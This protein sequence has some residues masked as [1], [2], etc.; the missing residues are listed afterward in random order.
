MVGGC[1]VQP[2]PPMID[3]SQ[4]MRDDHVTQ[5]AIDLEPEF[6]WPGWR[7]GVRHVAVLLKVAVEDTQSGDHVTD[8]KSTWHVDGVVKS[9]RE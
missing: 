9:S 4:R 5:F 6:V 8:R 2:E 7:D 1:Y 3:V